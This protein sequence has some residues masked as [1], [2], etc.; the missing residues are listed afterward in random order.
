MKRTR[1]VLKDNDPTTGGGRL[2]TAA[3]GFLHFGMQVG[4]EGDIAT[5][6]ACRSQG[7]VFNDCSPSFAIMGK[8]ILVEGA[9][10]Y[11][12]CAE[13][14]YVLHTQQTFRVEVS[15]GGAGREPDAGDLMARGPTAADGEIE[16]QY[17]EIVNLRTGQ[18]V[19]RLRYDL[20]RDGVAVA[21]DQSMTRGC[22]GTLHGHCIAEAVIWHEWSAA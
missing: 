8:S 2:I 1:Y 6:L 7:P 16:E 4:L 18:A 12:A 21:T 5:C 11:C 10:V 3:R 17:F 22:T 19:D 9:R 15:I 20:Y 13:K 14:P